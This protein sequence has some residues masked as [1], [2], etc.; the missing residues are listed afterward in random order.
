MI[1]KLF[2]KKSNPIVL[3]NAFLERGKQRELVSKIYL[4][5]KTKNLKVEELG[6]EWITDHINVENS[7]KGYF[8][9]VPQPVS[10]ERLLGIDSFDEEV[11]LIGERG[12]TQFKI[13]GVSVNNTINKADVIISRF[14]ALSVD[15]IQK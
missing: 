4:F 10:F 9:S 2:N 15:M 6:N 3:E 5:M 12:S 7:Y 8:Y 1:E 14:T 11:T 13:N